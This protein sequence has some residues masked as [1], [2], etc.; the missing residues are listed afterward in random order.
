MCIGVALGQID[1]ESST[2]EPDLDFV[3]D[4]TTEDS[5]PG[6]G[7]DV[8]SDVTGGGIYD[9]GCYEEMEGD[10]EETRESGEFQWEPC[11]SR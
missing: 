5:T 7:Y 3:D 6:E 10:A 9:A 1:T 11:S 2:L 8:M 4:T